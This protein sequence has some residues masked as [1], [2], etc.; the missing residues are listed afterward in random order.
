MKKWKIVLICVFVLLIGAGSYLYYILE[1]KEY[2]TADTQVDEITEKT[3]DVT[4]PSDTEKKQQNEAPI[5]DSATD[6]QNSQP[7]TE[8]PSANG[9]KKTIVSS[10][11]KDTDVNIEKKQEN[12]N[13]SASTATDTKNKEKPSAS[14]ITAKYEP[15]FK[16]LENQANS[17]VD[18][19]ISL[20]IAEYQA[21]RKN[22]ET[23]SYPYFYA[24]YTSAG[25]T[26]ESSA[27]AAFDIIYNEYTNEL[28]ING[29]DSSYAEKVKSHYETSKKERRN[30]LLKRAA[31]YAKE[32]NR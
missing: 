23:I 1:V 11:N 32:Q 8:S 29:F 19:L 13:T 9:D 16:D 14:N 2:N 12:K 25:K 15:S 26:L 4:L 27:D 28:K 20:A 10:N 6:E 17:R 24:K 21:K 31:K 3:F 30:N 22:N 5:E 18:K 7:T